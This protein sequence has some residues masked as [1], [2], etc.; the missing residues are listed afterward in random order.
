MLRFETTILIT[1]LSRML[2]NDRE[3]HHIAQKR[4]AQ[5]Y[6]TSIGNEN[7]LAS[8]DVIGADLDE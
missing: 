1:H 6:F 5:S 2:T 3:D 4:L 7:C 8:I